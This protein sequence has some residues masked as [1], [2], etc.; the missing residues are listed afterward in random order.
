METLSKTQK[1]ICVS[2]AQIATPKLQL[3]K[4]ETMGMEELPEEKDTNLA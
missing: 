4:V 1:R 3:T 2:F